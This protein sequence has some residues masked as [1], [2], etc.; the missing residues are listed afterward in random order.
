MMDD[1]SWPDSLIGT[2]INGKYRIDTLIGEGGM[3]KVFRVTHLEL[4]RIFALKLMR[5]EQ[6]EKNNRV[7]RF[8]RE[9]T[10][11]AKLNHPNIVAIVDFGVFKAA[12]LPFIVMEYIEGMTLRKLL[13]NKGTLTE[14]QA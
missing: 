3:G 13:H 4:N 2:V 10:L 11:L 8:R 14:S 12:Q 9:A 1:F 6:S 7:S 5:F